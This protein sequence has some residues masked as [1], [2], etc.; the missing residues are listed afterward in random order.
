MDSSIGEI[1][2]FADSFRS[3]EFRVVTSNKGKNLSG[4]FSFFPEIDLVEHEY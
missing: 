3:N 4:K 2:I 1:G